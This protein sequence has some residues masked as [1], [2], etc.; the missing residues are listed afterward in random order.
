MSKIAAATWCLLVCMFIPP[1]AHA[2]DTSLQ[3]I[4]IVTETDS[5]NFHSSGVVVARNTVATGCVGAYPA[6]FIHITT[7]DRQSVNGEVVYHDSVRNV[8]LV[9]V[10]LGKSQMAAAV[11]GEPTSVGTPVSLAGFDDGGQFKSTDG[12]IVSPPNLGRLWAFRTDAPVFNGAAGAAVFDARGRLVGLVDI[13]GST[14]HDPVPLTPSS[15]I[16]KALDD[17]SKGQVSAHDGNVL[18]TTAIKQ[19]ADSDAA[20]GCSLAKEDQI[21]SDEWTHR[22][23][24][25]LKTVES[26]TLYPST[27]T[28]QILYCEA[29]RAKVDPDV[30]LAFLE[31]LLPVS[32]VFV[33]APAGEYDSAPPGYGPAQAGVMLIS[34]WRLNRLVDPSLS[35]LPQIRAFLE[36]PEGN[37]RAGLE[38]LRVLLDATDNNVGLA[39]HSYFLNV[40]FMLDAM[41]TASLQFSQRTIGTLKEM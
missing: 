6:H 35:D 11:E 31:N 3:V 38:V 29:R 24:G 7:K 9:R 5:G 15:W 25:E 39:L 1:S 41:E 22:R 36:S 16:Q 19:V 12:R 30:L 18:T 10:D 21:A 32:S 2:K 17:L 27:L 26:S 23:A 34:G 28:P 13:V 40:S 33:L 20:N 8:C 14:L 37:L 4:G